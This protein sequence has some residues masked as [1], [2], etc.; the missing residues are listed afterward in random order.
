MNCP[1][2]YPREQAQRLVRDQVPSAHYDRD[3]GLMV[4]NADDMVQSVRRPHIYL[5]MN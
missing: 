4:L 1:S 5:P 2:T 3:M